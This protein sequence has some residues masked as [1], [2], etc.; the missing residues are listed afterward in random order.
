[1]LNK[2]KICAILTA[3]GGS[4]GL[5]KKNIM[6]LNGKP[7]IA[8]SIEA[9]LKCSYISGVYVTT[10]CES[11]A[12]VSQAF[13]AKTIK[14]P[15]ELATDTA[16][17]YDAVKHAINHLKNEGKN[18]CSFALLQP[19]S[20]LRNAGHLS[21]AIEV[22]LKT[23]AS[24]CV[25]FCEAE[26]HPYKDFIETPSG[27]HPVSKLEYASMPRQQLPK[28]YRQNGAIYILDNKAFLNGDESFMPPPMAPYIMPQDVSI[29]IDNLQDLK[30]A[31]DFLLSS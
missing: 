25:S 8:Y 30:K 21:E 26:H 15:K 23:N 9:A 29:D 3:R 7:L 20:P 18:Y 27:F 14:R 31:E 12:S 11:I 16:S 2:K 13:G 22:Y 28:A 4:K 19:T 6:D 10:D 1:M 5:P 24:S 17:S